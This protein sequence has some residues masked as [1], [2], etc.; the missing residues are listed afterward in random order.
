MT[1]GQNVPSDLLMARFKS[2]VHFS[3]GWQNNL[4]GFHNVCLFKSFRLY[5]SL[6]D[7]A[8]DYHVYSEIKG[9]RAQFM[10]VHSTIFIFSC[11]KNLIIANKFMVK[12]ANL[13][14]YSHIKTGTM[15][16][17]WLLIYQS[18]VHG[19][20]NDLKLNED[21]TEAFHIS[22]IIGRTGFSNRS[23]QKY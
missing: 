22:S 13:I 20:A 4:G 7:F 5:T 12:M 3:E 9:Q 8:L 23:W 17:Q 19:A 10:T 21:K 1:Y 2:Y 11:G 15:Y 6:R 16:Y 14:C 18:M